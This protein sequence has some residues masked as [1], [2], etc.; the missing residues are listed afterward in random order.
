MLSIDNNTTTC[1]PNVLGTMMDCSLLKDTSFFLIAISSFI[2]MVA[3][4]VPVVFLI[5]MAKMEV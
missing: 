3:Y 2:A 1:C 5:E 4:F